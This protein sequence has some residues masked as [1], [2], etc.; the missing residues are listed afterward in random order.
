M[1]KWRDCCVRSQGSVRDKVDKFEREASNLRSKYGN[2]V[3]TY[4]IEDSTKS[5]ETQ[6]K[7]EGVVAEKEPLIISIISTVYDDLKDIH[8]HLNSFCAPEP[9]PELVKQAQ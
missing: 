3:N 5:R 1:N 6:K 9:K 8:K 2:I 7:I 4:G